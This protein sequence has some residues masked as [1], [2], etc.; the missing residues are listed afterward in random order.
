MDATFSGD[1][2]LWASR[3]AL[4]VLLVGVWMWVIRKKIL[5]FA[6]RSNSGTPAAPVAFPTVW[7][8]LACTLTVFAYWFLLL[9]PIDR[10]TTVPDRTLEQR[11]SNA[12]EKRVEQAQPSVAP[13]TRETLDERAKR[14]QAENE[15][16]NKKA[17]DTFD[18]LKK[19]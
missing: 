1:L 4:T 9:Q 3:F 7:V 16:Q 11:R 19:R 18:A 14:M 8:A 10:T 17:K 5:P 15:A 13:D 2:F 12:A 6:R